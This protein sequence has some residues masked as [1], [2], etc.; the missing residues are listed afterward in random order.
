VGPAGYGNSTLVAS[1][2]ATYDGPS[3]LLLLNEDDNDLTLFLG[4]F[5]AAIHAL[6]PDALEETPVLLQTSPTAT[7]L[8]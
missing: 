2:L 7:G 6:F 4:Y 8:G 5:S 1:W 3:A